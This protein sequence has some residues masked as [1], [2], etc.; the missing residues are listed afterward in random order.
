MQTVQSSSR[1][2]S[3]AVPATGRGHGD[4]L[5]ARVLA[6]GLSALV[7]ATA[8]PRPAA[9][10]WAEYVLH[11]FCGQGGPCGEPDGAYP[12]ASLAIGEGRVGR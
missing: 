4:R 10:Q 8:A 9:D 7:A 12:V 6:L 1:R 3:L 11:A 5:V 2:R